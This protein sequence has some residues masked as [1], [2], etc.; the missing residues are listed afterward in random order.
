MVQLSCRHHDLSWNIC[1]TDDHG[2]VPFVVIHSLFGQDL[3]MKI[4][5]QWIFH[6]SKTT[7]AS[8]GFRVM[9]FNATFN[10]ILVISRRSALL[11]EETGVHR[12]A[13]S[14]A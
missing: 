1:V 13:S 14:G 7:Y 9:V 6:A 11:V 12:N 4:A 10:N 2:Y 5:Y 3:S 8:K